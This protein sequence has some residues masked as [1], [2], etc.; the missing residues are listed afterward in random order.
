MTEIIDENESFAWRCFRLGFKAYDFSYL[1]G[2]KK[3][4]E[5]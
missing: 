5:D 1:D 2:D 3:R 4:G